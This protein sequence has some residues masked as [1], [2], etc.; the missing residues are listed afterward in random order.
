MD[1]EDR[2]DPPQ[3][4]EPVRDAARRL[5]AVECSRFLVG[6]DPKSERWA[7][8]R[9]WSQRVFT[10]TSP[11][12]GGDRHLIVTFNYDTVL[13]KLGFQDGVRLPRQSSDK[14]ILK[15]H[16]SVNWKRAK[17]GHFTH[18]TDEHFA[19]SCPIEELAIAPPGPDKVGVADEFDDLWK[20]ATT[21]LGSA[22]AVV[23]IGYRFPQTDAQ[24]RDKILSALSSRTIPMHVVLGSDLHSV[25]AQRLRGLLVSNTP[26]T[27]VVM[28]PLFAQDFMP[29]WRGRSLSDPNQWHGGW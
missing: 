17:A 14:P 21:A 13:E 24:A 22:D 23:F 9:D 20:A 10:A 2:S 26:R 5:L 11:S 25:D 8:Y 27:P 15:L 16:G 1:E 19:A 18:E 28:H 4:I 7:P 3:S 29:L 6:A 12:K